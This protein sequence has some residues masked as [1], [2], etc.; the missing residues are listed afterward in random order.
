MNA[1]AVAT[2]SQA[3][4]HE[5]RAW[6]LQVTDT[7]AAQ[8]AAACGTKPVQPGQAAPRIP[9]PGSTFDDQLVGS[10]RTPTPPVRCS[11]SSRNGPGSLDAFVHEM[12]VGEQVWFGAGEHPG[13]DAAVND[14]VPPGCH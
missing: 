13:A 1:P 4:A 10:P 14:D 11:L 6:W 7:A 8:L 2:S 5:A 12:G 9:L 3:A